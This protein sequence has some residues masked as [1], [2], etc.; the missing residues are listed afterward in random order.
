MIGIKCKIVL[1]IAIL[2][3]NRGNIQ[4]YQFIHS[5]SDIVPDAPSNLRI[6]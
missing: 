6:I 5:G 2:H 3:P 1:P 4:I